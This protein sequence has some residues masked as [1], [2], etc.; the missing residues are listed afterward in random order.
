MLAL[1]VHL[2]PV[3]ALI[4]LIG[5]LKPIRFLLMP[6]R[7]RALMVLALGL[8]I[9]GAALAWPAGA[10]GREPGALEAALPEYH[11]IH[12]QSMRI[13]ASPDRIFDAIAH[14]TPYEMHAVRTLVWAHDPGNSDRHHSLLTKPF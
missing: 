12:R 9:T 2:G 10:R 6:T 11:F 7:L 14:V 1:M 5:V 13:H 3:I 4:G 8:V